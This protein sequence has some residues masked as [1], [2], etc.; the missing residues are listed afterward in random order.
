VLLAPFDRNESAGRLRLDAE[1]LVGVDAV[2]G[3][4][5]QANDQHQQHEQQAFKEL[6]EP[7]HREDPRLRA[8]IGLS[9]KSCLPFS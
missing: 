2:V 4:C 3:V 7:L 5:Y 1:S 6:Q 9:R 8:M